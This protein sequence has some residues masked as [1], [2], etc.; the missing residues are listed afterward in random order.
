MTEKLKQKT[1]TQ[2]KQKSQGSIN[3]SSAKHTGSYDQR[4]NGTFVVGIGILGAMIFLSFLLWEQ[5]E[6]SRATLQEIS[7]VRGA[8]KLEME[9]ASLER[10]QLTDANIAVLSELQAAADERK[11]ASGTLAIALSEVQAASIEREADAALRSAVDLEFRA[12]VENLK[13]QAE[14]IRQAQSETFATGLQASALTQSWLLLTSKSVGNSGKVQALEYLASQ[15]ESLDGIN[16]S[17]KMLGEIKVIKNK[18]K[19]IRPVYLGD[20]DLSV[21]TLGEGASL[22]KAILSGVILT[23][24][25]LSG[26]DLS[27]SVFFG[28]DLEGA[29]FRK[30]NLWFS[31]LRSA[32]LE[33]VNFSKANMRQAGLDGAN[34]QNAILRHAVLDNAKMDNV[35]LGGAKLYGASLVGARLKGSV[36]FET[37]LYASN[38]KDANFTDARL[39]GAD[40]RKSNLVNANFREASLLKA[41]FSGAN[42]SG[43]SFTKAWGLGSANFSNATAR[44]DN[45]PR[46]LPK[47]IR[48]CRQGDHIYFEL[49]I[50][51]S[52]CQPI[53]Q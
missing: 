30:T 50:P 36:L 38:L 46:G 39:L 12:A 29:D 13:S 7:A 5:L 6:T 51:R 10:K 19:C 31:N 9:A 34:L 41:N 18:E 21:D 25:K 22:H 49:S 26:A 32:D 1:A 48:R 42:I 16:L 17:C 23:D 35:D 15:G 2:A 28:S 11:L 24:A 45:P 14:L 33:G 40:L 47:T 52:N 20:L 27:N 53:T 8:Q 3:E 4:R 43:A 44:Y 37:N